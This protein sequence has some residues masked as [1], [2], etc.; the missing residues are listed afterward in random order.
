MQIPLTLQPPTGPTIDVLVDA[1]PDGTLSSVADELTLAAGRP[2][3]D[4]FAGSSRLSGDC[5]LAGGPIRAGAVLG[6]GAPGP[7]GSGAAGILQLQVVGGPCAG[8]TYPLPPG[9][10]IVGRDHTATVC[11]ADPDVSRRHLAIT[12]AR[13]GVRVRDLG[14]TNGSRVDDVEV[15][16]EPVTVRAGPRLR[17]GESTLVVAVACDPPAALRP[18]SDGALTVN[19]PP[20]FVPRRADPTITVPVE[21]PART[22]SRVPVLAS[23][24]PLLGGIGLAIFM[25]SPQYL[26][27]TVL[28]PIMLIGNVIS[29]RRGLRRGRRR[30]LAQYKKDKADAD[31]TL[32]AAVDADRLARRAE[33]PDPAT[34]VR[35]ALGPGQRLW[36]RRAADADAL[37]LGLGT[38][39]LPARV[40]LRPAVGNDPLPAP[41]VAEVPV[42]VALR[43][44]G[45][46]GIG[47]PRPPVEALTRS[48]VGQA[49]TLH[50]PRD[51]QLTLITADPA[52]ASWEW[53]RW[54][55]H[56]ADR[57]GLTAATRAARI[58]GLLRLLDTRRAEHSL[59]D[60][61]QPLPIVVLVVD[62]AAELRE[63]PGLARILAEGPAVGMYAIC[64][65]RSP[66]LLPA[67]CG[68]VVELGGEVGTRAR[69]LPHDGPPV[70]DIVVDGLDAGSAGRL[71]RALAPLCDGTAESVAG[72]PQ[73][74]R[75]L[76]LLGLE[77]PTKQAIR[78]RWAEAGRGTSAIIGEAAEGPLSVDL[79]RDGPHALV[80]GTTGAGKSELLQTI[81]AS[82]AVV[83]RPE[84]MTFVLI[85][86]KGG[87]AFKDCAHLP[88]T[89]GMVT[90]LDGH[91]TERA[92]ASLSAE[93][94]RR[95]QLLAGLGAKDIE[96]YW[97]ADPVEPMP[98]LVLVIDEFASLVEELPDFVTGLVGIAM[99]GRS[100]GVHLILATQRPSGVVSPVIRANTNL[101]I[102][103]RVTDDAESRDV[104]DSPWAAGIPASTPG[105]A[106][107][108]TG[109]LPAGEFQSARVGGRATGHQR[110]QGTVRAIPWLQT[111]AATATAVDPTGTEE[112]DLQELVAAIRAA[113]HGVQPRSPWLAP[114]P[115]LVTLD[116]LSA[117]EPDVLPYALADHPDRQCR[118]TVGLD[119]RR[120]E[121]LGVAGGP[122]SGR[123]SLLRTVVAAGVTRHSP[124]D[125]HIYALDCA[126]GGLAGLAQLPHCGA[127]CARHEVARGD[128][129]LT[130]LIEEM[131]RRQGT[132]AAAGFS[133]VAEQRAHAAP[134]D[135]LAWI[136]L[137]IDGWE[138]F[139]EAYEAVDAGRPV[140]AVLQLAREGPA[141][142]IQLVATGGRQLLTGRAGS[143]FA[144]RIVLR[145]PDRNDYGLA[146]LPLR[147]IPDQLP[148]GRGL[149]VAGPVELQVALPDA[150]RSGPHQV[151]AM[152]RL[153]ESALARGDVDSARMPFRVSPLPDYL[154]VADCPRPPDASPLWTVIG[155]A[156]DEAVTI[157][158]DLATDGPGFLVA[159]PPRS[160]RSAALRTIAVS[161]TGAG[162]P[163]VVVVPRRS[164]LRSLADRP[165]VIGVFDPADDDG[166]REA[167]AAGPLVVVVD[168]VH[169]MTDA[170]VTDVLVDLLRA[171]DGE[172]AVVAA[173][174]SDE[175][176][177]I[178]RGVPYEIR[179]SRTG[180][181]LQPSGPDGELLGVRIPRMSSSRVPGR[182]LLVV[183]GE[184]TPV[185]AA[186]TNESTG[187]VRPGHDASGEIGREPLGLA[188]L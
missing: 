49:A 87:A 141:M 91:L 70:A 89:V 159:G 88:H 148:D 188:R 47:G 146:G 33:I 137:L 178:F 12:V 127:V 62:G 5:P 78:R 94:K 118:A 101:R 161:L 25:H 26:I 51:V 114:L 52:A 31:R 96:D 167:V 37:V 121:A 32:A 43:E 4:I 61:S 106:F 8:A 135:R 95:E 123:T 173:G 170:P 102:A 138:G 42:A 122:R 187:V 18:G 113:A 158:V 54:L 145:L 48:L 17:I 163:V 24:L 66:R 34:I 3:A 44:V 111:G 2:G 36:E 97:R 185:Q 186:T 181:L 35:T 139:T 165:G 126:G 168:D 175:L 27:F 160:G 65:D 136:M 93:L 79:V 169:T 92:L 10:L 81:I 57:V 131:R 83:N 177:S 174:G 172:R 149:D 112:T 162:T 68:A 98:R 182:G 75:L 53:A 59:L 105:R 110:P 69:L 15:G 150:D 133:S 152:R 72:V 130:R 16:A 38:G 60:H 14:S 154:D 153:A 86:Y 125:L 128:R 45:V 67:E 129:V 140:D 71:A 41:T 80:A 155:A 76:P 164:P 142:G 77:S 124:A 157:G 29:E 46:L 119:L 99:R 120:S 143:M 144:S 166:L 84:A 7:S 40:S 28:S 1:D 23:L 115:A 183:G 85:D 176:G 109:A 103:L 9:E 156:G 56:L 20:R 134:A 39:D 151:A 104:I 184:C 171:D 64:I 6:V 73:S 11:L 74:S 19:R 58:G 63:L 21:P 108:R 100:L 13:D 30:E 107:V 82:L 90:D 180:L 147:S 116:E 22:P 132:L 55:P 179:T 117:D 50:S